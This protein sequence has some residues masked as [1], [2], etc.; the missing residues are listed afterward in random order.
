[1]G[2]MIIKNDGAYSLTKGLCFLLCLLLPRLI[3]PH[4]PY[5]VKE[6]VFFNFLLIF[7]GFYIMQPDPPHLLIPLYLPSAL[8]TSSPK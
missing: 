8:V 1:M 4:S 6:T 5:I 3:S 2:S 7:Y